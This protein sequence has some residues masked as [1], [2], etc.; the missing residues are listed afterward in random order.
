VARRIATHTVFNV[1]VASQRVAMAALAAPD[2]WLDDARRR[3]RI[4]RD[5]AVDALRGSGARTFAPADSAPRRLVSSRSAP[6]KFASLILA[7]SRYALT[8]FAPRSLNAAVRR[9][10]SE[11]H[12]AGPSRLRFCCR[13]EGEVR[14]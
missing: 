10:K 3:Y 1:P 12:R 6:S 2:A 7:S 9:L 13:G 8:R 11:R 5:T 4:A 14:D